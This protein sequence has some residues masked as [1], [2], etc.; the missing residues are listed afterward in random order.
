M[1]Y[2]ISE[3]VVWRGPTIN[4]VAKCELHQLM[5]SENKMETLIPS[6][7]NIVNFNDLTIKQCVSI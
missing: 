1:V 2:N 4:T 3:Y 7:M 6:A 5:T